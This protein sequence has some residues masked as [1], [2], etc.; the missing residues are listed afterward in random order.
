MQDVGFASGWDTALF[1]APFVAMMAM[2]LFRVDE[3]VTS[4]R[5]LG[6][7]G[8]RF[9]QLDRQGKAVLLDPDGH[10]W[11][12]EAERLKGRSGSEFEGRPGVEARTKGR[13]NSLR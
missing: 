1:M 4:R 2:S 6:K 11:T 13:I 5:R 8:R 12:Q 10:Q 3:K 9:C 7:A